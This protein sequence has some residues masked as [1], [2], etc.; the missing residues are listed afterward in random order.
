[1]SSP[2]VRPVRSAGPS[3]H[4]RHREG[5]AWKRNSR[6]RDLR[7]RR[8]PRH[9]HRYLRTGDMRRPEAFEWTNGRDTVFARVAEPGSESAQTSVQCPSLYP[10]PLLLTARG[11]FPPNCSHTN[12][13]CP[14]A[15]GSSLTGEETDPEVLGQG[16]TVRALFSA[17]CRLL[18]RRGLGLDPALSKKDLA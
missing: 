4:Q 11:P 18:A 3:W 16:L 14:P 6:R 10:T 15:N 9:P 17:G 12:R 5:L 1:M 13:P 2:C 7:G 8:E